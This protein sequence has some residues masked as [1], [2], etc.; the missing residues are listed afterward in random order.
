[1]AF[2]AGWQDLDLNAETIDTHNAHT[3]GAGLV[4]G[5]RYFTCPAG[6]AGR[7]A[8]GGGAVFGA[9]PAGSVVN[10]RILRNSAVFPG[11]TGGSA[12]ATVAGWSVVTGTKLL[13]LAVGDTVHV[14][15]YCASG[16]GTWDTGVF[17]DGASWM[18]VERID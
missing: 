8:V 18:S 6:Q 14:Q 13:D 17:T 9:V 10:A 16:A 4:A 5:Q 2:A 3:T 7:Y 11:C 1:V 12:S 15:G